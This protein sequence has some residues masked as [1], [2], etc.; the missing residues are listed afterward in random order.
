MTLPNEEVLDLLRERFVLGA[1]NIERDR[2]VGASHGYRCTQS[3]VGT[4]NGAGGRNVQLLVLAADGTV[5]HALP[6]FWHPA[7]LAAELRLALEL[8]SLHHDERPRDA[9]LAMWRSLHTAAGRAAVTQR[10]EWQHFDR[11]EELMRAGREPRD[12]VLCDS[13]GAPLLDAHGQ[14]QLKPIRQL[15]H[16]RLAAQP[17]VALAA[18]DVEAFVDYGRAY[19]DNNE[20]VDDGK[21]FPRAERSVAQREKDRERQRAAAAKAALAAARRTR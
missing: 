8:H 10:D 14:M 4:T 18:F 13:G 17:F 7:E 3:A 2:H 6:G 20:W 19:Y 16:D 5:V 9:K 15:V 11:H 21:R 12:T 1:H